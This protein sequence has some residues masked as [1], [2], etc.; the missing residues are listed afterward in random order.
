VVRLGQ[1]LASRKPLLFWIDDV[2]W[3][4]AATRDLLRYATSRWAEARAPVLV[5]VCARSEEIQANPALRRWLAGL[6]H[7]VAMSRLD[8]QPLRRE[9]L[10][11][12][13]G[14]LLGQDV[15]APPA[16]TVVALAEWLAERT[17]GLPAHVS[18]VLG[19]LLADGALR[20]QLLD[21]SRRV[22]DVP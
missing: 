13:V 11:Q 14:I 12:L 20:R 16:S 8:L 10:V 6:E 17:G 5:V 15:E 7:D 22:V 2:Q 19:E 18:Q 21:G 4:G 1:A 9:D 3:A